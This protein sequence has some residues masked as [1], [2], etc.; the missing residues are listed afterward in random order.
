[1]RIIYILGCLCLTAC[2][3]FVENKD[4]GVVAEL[5]GEILTKAELAE[6][7][8]QLGEADSMIVVSEHIRNWAKSRLL[9]EQAKINL[10]NEQIKDFDQLV[11]D[12]RKNLYSKAYLDMLL[13]K[14]SDTILSDSIY[15]DF[16]KT[17]SENFTLSEDIVRVQYIHLDKNLSA[18][19][20]SKIEEK[21]KKTD[22]DSTQLAEFKT[23]SFLPYFLNGSIWISISE[24]NEKVGE[25]SSSQAL[26]AFNA[27]KAIKIEDPDGYFL[28][29]ILDYKPQGE[30][31]PLDFLKPTLAK[32]IIQKR[33][34][35]FLET[36]QNELVDNAIHEK[37]LIVYE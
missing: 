19:E 6:V 33:K 32:L 31:P 23:A 5:D 7:G 20:R 22:L 12:Y 21:F 36:L 3:Y 28:I 11:E 26:E 9:F 24:V 10:S 35:K 17:R 25:L 18:P 30:S 15:E 1:M 8:T 13:E 37:K 27:H 4:S 34:Q 29:K 16:Y 14:F 2:Q